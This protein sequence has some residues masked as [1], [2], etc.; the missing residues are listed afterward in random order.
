MLARRRTS[1]IRRRPHD[2]H[3]RIR[4]ERIHLDTNPGSSDGKERSAVKKQ[5]QEEEVP[6]QVKGITTSAKIEHIDLLRPVY[7]QDQPAGE[8]K[9]TLTDQ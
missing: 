6:L 8:I 3:A 2:S 9:E 5:V 1:W 7:R 4:K